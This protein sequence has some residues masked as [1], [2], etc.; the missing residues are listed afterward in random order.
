MFVTEDIK[1]IGIDKDLSKGCQNA[2][3]SACRPSKFVYVSHDSAQLNVK[4]STLLEVEA[5]RTAAVAGNAYLKKSS[6]QADNRKK[7]SNAVAIMKK[8]RTNGKDEPHNGLDSD[9]SGEEDTT[10][11][12]GELEANEKSGE[13]KEDQ[14]VVFIQDVGFTVKIQSPGVEMFDIQVICCNI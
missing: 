13:K 12:K 4:S 6:Q 1:N 10:V 3:G 8:D 7:Q 2:D 9:A 11:E 5:L 14:D